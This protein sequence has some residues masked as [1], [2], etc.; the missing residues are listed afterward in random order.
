MRVKEGKASYR[1]CFQ[2]EKGRR[3]FYD[4]V[5]FEYSYS[6][7]DTIQN[8]AERMLPKIELEVLIT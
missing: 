4:A 8:P 5:P 2:V 1:W 6:H 3:I 7:S